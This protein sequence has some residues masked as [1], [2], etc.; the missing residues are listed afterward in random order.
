MNKRGTIVF[1]GMAGGRPDPIDPYFLYFYNS[2][3]FCGGDCFNYLETPEEVQM[4]I[5]AVFD[6]Y[7][8]GHL[9]ADITEIVPLERASDIHRKLE[10]RATTGKFVLKVC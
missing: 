9:K 7:R 2:I 3:R 5:D 10:S 4:R 8:K 1:Y 6:D